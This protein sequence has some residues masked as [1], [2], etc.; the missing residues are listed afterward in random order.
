[1]EQEKEPLIEEPL[2]SKGFII[3]LII[4]IILSILTVI[5]VLALPDGNALRILFAI[6]FLLFIPGYALVSFLWTKKGDLGNLER[7]ALSFGLSI[8][9]IIVLGLILNYTPWGLSLLLILMSCFGFII[10]FS[11]LALYRRMKTPVEER[12]FIRFD[13]GLPKGELP[14]TDK[15]LTI[16][17][18]A[19]LIVAGSVLG[20]VVVTQKTGER[21]TEFYILDKNGTTEDYPKNLTVGESKTIIVGI[22]NH[23]GERTNYSIKINLLNKTDDMND[24]WNYSIAVNDDERHEFNFDFSIAS[25]DTYRLEFLLFRETDV[26]PY[27]ELHLNDI[28]VRD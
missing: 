5:A 4:I 6:P 25:N 21:Y 15:I 28:M 20:Y 10:A 8:A 23:E 26:E 1:M 2:R 7:I 13:F 11:M 16:L 24:T 12:F 14:R 19:S 22:V 18:V 27:L 9:I 3:D 17:I